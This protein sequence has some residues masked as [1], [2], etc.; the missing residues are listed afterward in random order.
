[1]TTVTFH[2]FLDYDM[3]PTLFLLRH[4]GKV[5]C[6]VL[7]RP[8]GASMALFWPMA[9]QALERPSFACSTHLQL[10]WTILSNVFFNIYNDI[11]ILILQ[12][13]MVLFAN[14]DWSYRFFMVLSVLFWR[15]F[16]QQFKR[17]ASCR[18][19]DAFAS[20]P[21]LQGWRS[22]A[23]AQTGGLFAAFRNGGYPQWMVYRI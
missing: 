10:T 15:S 11:I 7:D 9:K 13:I 5:L 3:K 19:P 20:P 22:R 23:P 1:M 6:W 21:I 18:P 2:I 4:D 12:S 8:W 17:P 16:P 14:I